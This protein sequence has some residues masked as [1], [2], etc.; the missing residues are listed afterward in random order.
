MKFRH[1]LLILAVLSLGA[2]VAQAAS[3]VANPVSDSGK[4]LPSKRGLAPAMADKAYGDPI[5]MV[6][7][8]ALG[9]NYLRYMQ[10]DVSE[11]I[12]NAGNG[13]VDT[14]PD[15]GGWDW[16]TTAFQHSTAASPANINGATAGGL[17]WVY[18]E[19]GDPALFTAMEE[20]ADHM[21]TTGP[22]AWAHSGPDVSFLLEFAALPAVTNPSYYQNGAL[23]I[24]NYQM[25]LHTDATGLAVYVRDL[26]HGQG[27][28]NGIIPWDIA[29]WSNAAKL[30]DGAFPGQGFDQAAIDIAEVIYQDS[31]MGSPGY[32]DPDG[33]NKG[34]DP[35]WSTPIYYWYPLGVAGIIRA[36]SDAGVHLDQLSAM[37]TLLLDCQY[38]DGGFSDQYGN[39]P[40]YNFRSYQDTAYA[41]WALHE[42]LPATATTLSALH[43]G[44]YWLSYWMDT[45]TG[46]YLYGD[47]SHYPEEGGECTKAIMMGAASPYASV[48]ASADGPDPA[49][50]GLTK[51]VTFHYD[52]ND[53]TPGLRG[54]E[55]TFGL[56]DPNT[57][58]TFDLSD[59]ADGG[60]LAGIGG[61][62]FQKV[63]N[64]DGTYTVSDA[65]LGATTGLLADGDLFTVK[66]TTATDGPVDVNIL[67]Y[68]LRD[69][70]NAFMFADLAGT[71]FVVD[72][73]AP[74]AVTD[75]TAAPGHNKVD[76]SWTH[77]GT[78]TAVYE[79][80]RGLWYDGA[81]TTSAYPEYDDLPGTIP[82][83][84]ADRDAAYSSPEWVLAGTVAVG[85]TS[86]T[87]IGEVGGSGAFDPAGADRGVYYYEVFAVDAATNGSLAAADGNDRATNYWLGDVDAID[88]Y[89]AVDDINAL[90]T[91]FA[92]S[93]GD[94]SG[95]YDPAIDV[96]PTDDWSGM[97]IPLTDNVID[98][99]DLMVFAM[100]FGQ[101]GPAKVKGGQAGMISL[102]WVAGED[103]SYALKLVSGNGLQG[104]HL[105]AAAPV[106]GVQAGDLLKGQK[107]FMTNAGSNL[108]ANLAVLGTGASIS[109]SGDLIVLNA[110]SPL[111]PEDLTI[112]LRGTDNAKLDY[113]LDKDGST[114][115]PT[116]FKLAANYPNPFNPMT[117]ISFSL[118]EAQTVQLAVYSVDG[119]KVATLVSGAMSAGTHEVV[120]MGNDDAGH[121][122][123]SG[124]YFY[125]IRAG[126]FNEVRKMTLVK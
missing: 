42:N 12:D 67:S 66:L 112:D 115:T 95:F 118:P 24:W 85:T 20:L 37:Q 54:Y 40:A 120:W 11:T 23:A 124:T 121:S 57:A 21:V 119:R 105:S 61:N 64:G 47:G 4:V 2:V 45:G 126:N 27:L 114:A 49:T 96:G 19:N 78:D 116:V 75:I 90:G 1:L 91:A 82:T 83:R 5:D 72:C 109:G 28:D 50:C 63:N 44:A 98:F 77:D 43:W 9:A 69:P 7:K 89:V 102:A 35:A 36:F 76:V 18:R 94:G 25:G 46:A 51:T 73:T 122:V 62:Y 106:T 6:A 59:I 93:D 71:S 13:L 58:V 15:D 29:L 97:G 87:D 111:K 117:K 92:T 32:F 56:T 108:D 38:D 68:K 99:E 48:T 84:P 104:V 55:I 16:S 107:I 8:G 100:N 10:A 88:G 31:F 39:D 3:P 125:R 52:R 113:T 17:I 81:V 79:V 65:I 26:R 22:A 80:Y 34:F 86:F 14:D 53:A 74:A 41:V 123:A 60:A 103:G 101:V 30:L 110:K 70:D 33:I